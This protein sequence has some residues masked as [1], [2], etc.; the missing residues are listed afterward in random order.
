MN[1][2]YAKLELIK[3]EPWSILWNKFL[4]AFDI[5]VYRKDMYVLNVSFRIL[6]LKESILLLLSLR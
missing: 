4:I 3:E 6:F 5:K 1:I 2:Q